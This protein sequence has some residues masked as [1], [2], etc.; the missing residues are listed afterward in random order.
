M[1][2]FSDDQLNY[3]GAGIHKEAKLVKISKEPA[4]N[5]GTGQT[6]LRFTYQ[7]DIKIGENTTPYF[8]IYT[9]F[10]VNPDKIIEFNVNKP[11]SKWSDEQAVQ[12]ELKWFSNKIKHILGTFVPKDKLVFKINE[13]D[14][15][16]AWDAFCD[17]VIELAGKSYEGHSFDFKLVLDGKD[18]PGFPKYAFQ[19]FIKNSMNTA[20]KLAIIPPYER[21]EPI[22]QADDSSEEWGTDNK[23]EDN[24]ESNDLPF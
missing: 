3:L 23:T 14:L 18:R 20:V 10:P 24:K 8:Y 15:E 2:N 22:E 17:K 5:D 1:Y 21:T 13:K 7:K 19:P 12:N 11:N 4:K 6:V 16:K 9:A